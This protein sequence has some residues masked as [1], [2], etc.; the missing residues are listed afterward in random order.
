MQ[1]AP[2]APLARE[3]QDRGVGAFE[4][5]GGHVA[6]E[7]G[8]ALAPGDAE[9][10]KVVTAPLGFLEDGVLGGDID[11]Q[12]GAHASIVTV[13]EFGDILEYGFF[14]SPQGGAAAD[15]SAPLPVGA[16]ARH[17]KRAHPRAAGPRQGEGMLSRLI[18]GHKVNCVRDAGAG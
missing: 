17:I 13:A 7:Q 18:E 10:D 15:A 12:R 4:H 1:I 3:E 6:E 8:F 9:H 14:V 5:R 11:A 2:S 16:A